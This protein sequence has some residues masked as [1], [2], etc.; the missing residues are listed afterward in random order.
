MGSP[1]INLDAPPP[2]PPGVTGQVGGG[3]KPPDSPPG[4]SVIGGSSGGVN[5]AMA[6]NPQGALLAQKS[7][8][9]KVLNQMSQMSPVFAPFAK[10]AL[11]T[12]EA[13]IN[14]A[15]Q[16]GGQGGGPSSANGSSMQPPADS[17][18]GS[19]PG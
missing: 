4:P 5:G 8:V 11:D 15:Q 12:I 18:K 6:M 14:A 7:A 1:A 17:G 13:G 3:P 19:F 9:E 16:G 10:R 2:Q